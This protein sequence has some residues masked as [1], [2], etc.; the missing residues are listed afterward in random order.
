MVSG[1]R[2]EDLSRLAR[3]RGH[4][5]RGLGHGLAVYTASAQSREHVPATIL[6]S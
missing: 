3:G 5:K 1:C 4:L 6:D 2:L